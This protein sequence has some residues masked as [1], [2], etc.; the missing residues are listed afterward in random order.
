MTVFRNW[1]LTLLSIFIV[2]LLIRSG[3][4]LTLQNGFYFPDSVEYSQ[5]AVNLLA[6][7][8]L[9]ESYHRP[10]GYPVFLAGIYLF[11]GES[12][13]A[14]RMVESLMGALLVVIIALIGRRVAGEVVGAIAGLL[15][16]I[17]PIGVFITGL[18]YP[19]NLVTLLLAC[20]ILCLL[21]SANQEP[22]PKRFFFSG[23][24]LGLAVLTIPIVLVTIGA[25]SL[26]LMCSYRVNRLV[27]V[28][29]L[30]LGSALTI[31]PWI[32]RDFYAY[33]RLVVVEPRVVEHLPRIRRSEDNVQDSKTRTILK[34]PR[35]FVDHLLN[36]FVHFWK[37][38]PDRIAM[39]SPGFREKQHEVDGRVVKNTI[40]STSNLINAVSILSTGPLFFFAIIGTAAMWF[41]RDRRR[42]L[43]LL[44]AAILSFA[45]GYSAF[46][47][48]TRY[49]IPIEP[50]ITILSAYG[51]KT[52]W[53]MLV[54]RSEF[55]VPHHRDRLENAGQT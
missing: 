37:L 23:V 9:G 20:S 16:S 25:I 35:V 53:S 43:L 36:E 42:N 18:I 39:D 29:L 7:G 13:L 54:A 15:W 41:R 17:Y 4:V 50:Y 5:G 48:K 10:P 49:R 19:T 24:T 11:F 6:N 52:A 8:E 34:H 33:G 28:S 12:I 44:W 38:Y 55:G 30:F 40:F 45:V 27:L 47:T 32:I 46:Y 1:R 31:A 21:P 3:F 14:V 26:W 2:A 22:T 51:L